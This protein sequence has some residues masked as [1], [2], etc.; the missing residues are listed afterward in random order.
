MGFNPVNKPKENHP[1]REYARIHGDKVKRSKEHKLLMHKLYMR[2]VRKANPRKPFSHREILRGKKH[3]SML[4]PIKNCH[5]VNCILR[6]R[7][8]LELYYAHKRTS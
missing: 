2:R 8:S 7:Y 6:R 4:C 3:Q 5:C 1:W